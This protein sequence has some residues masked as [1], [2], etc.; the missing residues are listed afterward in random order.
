LL[1]TGLSAVQAQTVGVSLNLRYT[2]PADPSAG[3]TWE[4]VGRVDSGL[5]ISAVNAILSDV[6]NGLTDIVLGD[7]TAGGGSID[8]IDPVDPTGTPRPAY[9]AFGTVTDLIYG[10]DISVGAL[11][12]VGTG[13]GTPGDNG[14]DVLRNTTWDNAALLA[15]GEFSTATRPDFTTN[16][17]S[18]TDANVFFSVAAPI[19]AIAATAVT[20][21]VR[22]D[23]LDTLLLENT[24]GTGLLAGDANRDGTVDI[25]DFN[26][27]AFGFNGA[28]TWDTGDF[29]SSGTKTID[30]FNLLAF[31][32]N[33]SSVPP[34]ISGLAAAGVPEPGTLALA[35][36]AFAS[37]LRLRRRDV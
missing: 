11:A 31:N 20:T 1:A 28:G 25:G 24:V 23:S 8:A 17:T 7:G 22:G 35:S 14:V 16:G 13:I 33:D 32:F 3:G 5:G 9:L 15:S 30:D 4:L 18:S 19:S 27:L 10:Q 26:L 12:G 2:D 34:A 36:I 29:N 21:T 37:L 6:D